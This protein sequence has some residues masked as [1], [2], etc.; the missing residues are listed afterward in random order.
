MRDQLLSSEL[1]YMDLQG[2]ERRPDPDANSRQHRPQSS[3]DK[4][5]ADGFYDSFAVILAEHSPS[6][7][8]G[9]D[10]RSA[11]EWEQLIQ[12]GFATKESEGT[13]R[14]IV[15][16]FNLG[17][18][19]R[20][21]Q[22]QMSQVYTYVKKQRQ[23]LHIE[24]PR[25]VSWQGILLMVFGAMSFLI[26]LAL[27]QFWDSED[28]MFGSSPKRNRKKIRDMSDSKRMNSSSLKGSMG[29]QNGLGSRP[30]SFAYTYTGYPNMKSY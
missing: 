2:H 5:D 23:Q 7:S 27:G 4:P 17:H 11:R 1:T 30:H 25:N 20:R 3:P 8:A 24:E 29:V 13:Y 10:A 28:D 14:V 26:S 16:R 12:R 18:T 6:S 22:A 19:F 9:N 21:V 15:R